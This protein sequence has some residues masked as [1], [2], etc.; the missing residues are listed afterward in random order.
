MPTKP[1]GR[2]DGL[3]PEYAT[4]NDSR[5][6]DVHSF[7]GGP[8]VDACSFLV[9]LLPAWMPTERPPERLSIVSAYT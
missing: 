9:R 1:A 7:V 6:V 2:L 3:E 4:W 8:Q 5:S